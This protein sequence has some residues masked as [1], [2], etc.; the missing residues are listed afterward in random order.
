MSVGADGYARHM[1]YNEQ[2][3]RPDEANTG[4]SQRILRV[5]VVSD[6]GFASTIASAIIDALPDHVRVDGAAV[7]LE[8]ARASVT[9]PPTATGSAQLGQW[10][11]SVQATE[12]YDIV[13]CVSE[14][15][16]RLRSRPVVA[17]LH[18][19]STGALYVPSF[20]TIAVRRRA[21]R[22]A[23]TVLHELLGTDSDSRPPLTQFETRWQPSSPN[24]EDGEAGGSHDRVLLAS[25]AFG[26]LRLISGMIRCNRPWRLVPTL[27]GALAAAS[28]ASAFGVFYASIWQMASSMTLARLT[29]IG[30]LAV[31]AMTIWL[32]FPHGLWEHRAFRASM[33]DRSMYNAATV[34]TVLTGVLCMY[35]V[36]FAVVLASSAVVIP[37]DFLSEQI[38]RRASL[39]DYLALAWL[40]ASLGIVAGAVGSSVANRDE[41]LNATYGHRELMRRR[42]ADLS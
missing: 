9:L 13:L 40:A 22:S 11:E 34:G 14:V 1:S 32:I 16:R 5:G 37:P 33:T 17:E 27:S 36:L 39:G 29:V 38:G 2:H 8:V 42:A 15:P 4:H 25:G 31:V 19:N 24:H 3:P 20:G 7:G 41:I 10:L 6:G 30:V 28:A 26:R 18:D 21:I 12:S 23:I 35:A